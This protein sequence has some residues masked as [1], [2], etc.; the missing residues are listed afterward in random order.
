MHLTDPGGG[1]WGAR[2]DASCSGLHTRRAPGT[3]RGWGKRVSGGEGGAPHGSPRPGGTPV[4]RLGREQAWIGHCKLGI[5]GPPARNSQLV[6]G[7]IS[8]PRSPRSW[9]Q[10]REGG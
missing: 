5:R 2:V 9:T 3:W 8:A 6:S 4:P 1:A 7:P 10:T